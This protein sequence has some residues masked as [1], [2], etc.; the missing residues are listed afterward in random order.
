[1][2]QSS[3]ME[4]LPT[5]HNNFFQFALSHLP[6]A[7]SL[8]ETQL[9]SA[10]LAELNLD[11]LQLESG[12][13][14][15]TDLRE[16]FSD[17]LLSVRLADTIV[18]TTAKNAEERALVYFLFEH[19]S[20]SDPL[21]VF[22]LLTY[23]VRIWEKRLRDG[24]PLCPIV[25][26]VVY[27]GESGWTAA[28]SIS[29]LVRSPKGLTDYQVNFQFPRMDLS[30]LSDEDISG[31]PILQSTLRLLKYSRSKFLVGKLGDILELIARSL[32]A[33]RLSDWI[34]AIGVYVMSVNNNIDSQQYKQTLK[35]VFP[36]Q[37]E[38]GSLADRLLIQGREEGREEGKLG[39]KIQM[40]QELLGDAVTSDEDLLTRDRDTLT[41]ELA[42][43][44]SRL[45][46]RDT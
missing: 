32:P 30:Q 31:G 5:P 27:H 12:S 24:L 45:R 14:I 20:Q 36:T 38:P 28:R 9:S 39:G 8:I 34:H 43:L 6:N 18:D 40:L 35:S 44:Q 29:E 7:R 46:R 17:L 15:D 10:A 2:I 42:A 23:I 13:F 26:L 4:Q 37:F 22:Q 25:P 41:A 21:T 11:T 16:K 1:M 19:K 33:G 3:A